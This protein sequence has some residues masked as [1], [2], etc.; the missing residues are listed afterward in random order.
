MTYP[1]I[2]PELARLKRYKSMVED[3]RNVYK[4]RAK[5]DAI[6]AVGSGVVFGLSTAIGWGLV[7]GM[8]A[9]GAE[10][11]STS[12]P[13]SSA[14]GLFVWALSIPASLATCM[15]ATPFWIYNSARVKEKDVKLDSITAQIKTVEKGVLQ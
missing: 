5:K 6:L 11:F 7:A 15:I 2:G 13:D 8:V 9:N 14:L 12:L 4:R 3:E 10:S 1:Y